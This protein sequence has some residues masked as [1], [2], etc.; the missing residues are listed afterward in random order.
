MSAWIS[1]IP[2]SC[3]L[4]LEIIYIWGTVCTEKAVR[5][6]EGATGR[7]AQQVGKTSLVL[8]L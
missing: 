6:G 1:G 5:G 4:E 7:R 8:H 2:A 3:D